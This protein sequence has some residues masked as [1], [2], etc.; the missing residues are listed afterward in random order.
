VPE[1]DRARQGRL[2]PVGR[3]LE[4]AATG[5]RTAGGGA[6]R[7][8]PV[9]AHNARHATK[10]QPAMHGPTDGRTFWIDV[11]KSVAIYLVVF[12]HADQNGFTESFLFTFHV[13]LFF[14]V[15]GYLAK[16]QGD[17]A[18]LRGLGRKLVLPY[19]LI[20]VVVALVSVVVLPGGD[21]H[22]LPRMLAGI[23]YGTHSYPYFVNDAMWFL[24][25]LITVELLYVFCLRRFALSYLLF[26]GTSYVLYRR[27]ELDLFL[28]IDLSLL[29]LNYFLAGA[30]VPPD[31]GSPAAPRRARRRL[32]RVHGGRGLGR[33]R[34]V[35]G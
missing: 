5:R 28:S 12:S 17:G 21:V 8:R 35:R 20:Y 27:H 26:L 13:P 2:V 19:I 34:V 32:H 30:L 7:R 31:R 11:A 15:S 16:P 14:F 22:A 25:S 24:P 6:A 29:G 10:A 4:G 1:R 33:Q 18:F 3:A 9:A 23:V